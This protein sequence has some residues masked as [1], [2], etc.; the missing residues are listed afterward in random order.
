MNKTKTLT[1][2]QQTILT[3]IYRYRFV[4]TKHVQQALKIKYLANVQPRMNL[5]VEGQYIGRNYS[6]SQ[7]L[8]GQPASYY[9][10]P[11]GMAALKE[12]DADV[13]RQ[14]LHNI[15][16]DKTAQDSFI[17]RCLA[18]GDINIELERQ[19]EDRLEFF[20]QSE[21]LEQASDYFPEPLPHAY[22]MITDPTNNS[23]DPH[24]FF[25]EIC[26]STRPSFVFKKRI[27]QYIQYAEEGDW[28]NAT[29]SDLPT[30]LLV[31][32][33][34]SMQASLSKFSKSEIENSYEDR[35]KIDVI[36]REKLSQILDPSL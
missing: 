29:A 14:V 34:R 21:I 17:Q 18:V 30:I 15:Y 11:K 32:D 24:T 16:K 36:T 2:Q 7:R 1:K 6:S 13:S 25:L 33:T 8:A 10:L 22:F 19:Y 26:E 35:L 20:T 3:L 31:C 4:S 12:F 5:L 27:Q 28:K 23:D 9:L